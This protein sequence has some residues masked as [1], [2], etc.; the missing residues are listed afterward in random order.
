MDE[1]DNVNVVEHV[2][3]KGVALMSNRDFIVLAT[4]FVEVNNNVK[5]I[6]CMGKGIIH[7]EAPETEDY[8]RA[9]MAFNA[10]HMIPINAN[11]TRVTCVMEFDPKGTISNEKY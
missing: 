1:M 8:V 11:S 5:E 7:E 2:C 3:K 9:H 4:E 6:Y 10:V